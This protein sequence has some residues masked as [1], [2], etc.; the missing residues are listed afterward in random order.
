MSWHLAVIHVLFTRIIKDILIQAGDTRYN[1]TGAPNNESRGNAML[2]ECGEVGADMGRGPRS[3]R[4]PPW[5]RERS[6]K[7][8]EHSFPV[9]FFC[10]YIMCHLC[11]RV[12]N[13]DKKKQNFHSV[14]AKRLKIPYTSN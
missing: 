13:K 9:L 6:T 10:A 11:Q 3:G 5:E 8:P 2:P 1:C 14:T 7:E 12:K 4:G